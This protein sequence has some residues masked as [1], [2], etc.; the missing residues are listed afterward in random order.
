M[1][2]ISVNIENLCVS[3][4][5]RNIGNTRNWGKQKQAGAELGKA[6]D[7]LKIVVDVGAEVQVK[8]EVEVKGNHY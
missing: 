2:K 8:V 3:R 4:G 7:K 6:H 5:H 1:I